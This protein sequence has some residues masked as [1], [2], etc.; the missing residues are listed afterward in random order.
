MHKI[1][2]NEFIVADAIIPLFTP[3]IWKIKPLKKYLEM[4]FS[5]RY[6]MFLKFSGWRQKEKNVRF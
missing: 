1:P 4:H 5:M 2:E 3:P 6:H